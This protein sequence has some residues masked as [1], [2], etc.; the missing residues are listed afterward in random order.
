MKSSSERSALYYAMSTITT[1]N[2]EESLSNDWA[3]GEGIE[4]ALK[5]WLEND[6]HIIHP[7]SCTT[8]TPASSDESNAFD[9]ATLYAKKI[10]GFSSKGE[11]SLESN[12]LNNDGGQLKKP[13]VMILNT[14]TIKAASEQDTQAIGGSH[15]QCC[16]ILPKNYKPL[17]KDNNLNNVSEI[18]FYLDSVSP[19]KMPRVFETAFREGCKDLFISEKKSYDHDIPPA[20]PHATIIDNVNIRPQA[21]GYDCGWWAVYNALMIVFTGDT[22]YLKQFEDLK[23]GD[24]SPALKLRTLLPELT[25]MTIQQ[26][27]EKLSNHGSKL[28]S[29]LA[30]KE[31]SAN[32]ALFHGPAGGR[33]E[34]AQSPA[35]KVANDNA[36]P[37]KIDVL[38]DDWA[39]SIPNAINSVPVDDC[40]RR[41]LKDYSH[42]F[43]KDL[44]DEKFINL[45]ITT[46]E[47]SIQRQQS[48]VSS[49]II[50]ADYDEE[51]VIGIKNIFDDV[52]AGEEIKKT[53]KVVIYGK[54]GTGKS[55][56]CQHIARKKGEMFGRGIESTIHIKL[57]QFIN[58]GKD[59]R[60]PESTEGAEILAKFLKDRY[61]G[62]TYDGKPGIDDIKKYLVEKGN[63]TL[64][65]LDGYDEVESQLRANSTFRETINIILKNKEF[66]VIV[67]TRPAKI[68]IN[69]VEFGFDKELE[70][71]GFTQQS[72]QE[73]ITKFYGTIDESTK[74]YTSTEQSHA[75]EKYVLFNPTLLNIATVPLNLDL[76]C[77]TWDRIPFDEIK[78]KGDD[79]QSI[80]NRAKRIVTVA[81]LYQMVT[82][83]I[84]DYQVSKGS[85][86]RKREILLRYLES[87]AHMGIKDQQSY[88][89]ID[90]VK[91][92]IGPQDKILQTRSL[93]K[94]LLD[95]G[96]IRSVEIN[97]A[98][99][100]I[101][102]HQTFMEYFMARKIARGFQDS[103]RVA[104][105][106]SVAIIRNLEN[107]YDP[108]YEV[109]WSRVVGI[110]SSRYIEKGDK[111][112]LLKFWD[113][114]ENEPREILG[115]IHNELAVKLLKECDSKAK[116]EIP[117]LK[118]LNERYS[119]LEDT[120]T[121]L[122]NL[123]QSDEPLALRLQAME[124]L[125]QI[126][127][128]S[129]DEVKTEIISVLDN[130][131][132]TDQMLEINLYASESLLRL[133]QVKDKYIDK[134]L[135][136]LNEFTLGIKL[137]DRLFKVTLANYCLCALGES[138]VITE[139]LE[140][141]LLEALVKKFK[142][143]AGRL[144]GEEK[145]VEKSMFRKVVQHNITAAGILIKI[146]SKYIDQA[147]NL[148]VGK[149]ADSDPDIKQSTV[150]IL[151]K[152]KWDVRVK[153]K[154]DQ[155][156]LSEDNT[157]KDTIRRIDTILPLRTIP[158]KIL[159]GIYAERMR[160]DRINQLFLKPV[161]A[162]LSSPKALKALFYASYI[163]K[164]IL[165][166]LSKHLVPIVIPIIFL[167][168][169]P[170][171]INCY[172]DPRL[173]AVLD[174]VISNDISENELE[175][176]TISQINAK[177]GNFL[178]RSNIIT[179]WGKN[180][181]LNLSMAIQL[182]CST[183]QS[184]W[185]EP[186]KDI[187]FIRK[188][189]KAF[190][191]VEEGK[192]IKCVKATKRE[193][194]DFGD[195]GITKIELT[196]NL[197]HTK[198]V[199]KALRIAYEAA[200]L[201]VNV[202]DY[203]LSNTSL[204]VTK[205]SDLSKEIEDLMKKPYRLPQEKA[206]RE[207]ASIGN[208]MKVKEIF[209]SNDI[210]VNGKDP[211]TGN[212]ALMLAVMNE[213]WD[214][215]KYLIDEKGADVTFCNNKGDTVLYIIETARKTER[216]IKD[217]YIN[218]IIEKSF[219][220]NYHLKSILLD[221]ADDYKL[222]SS[223]EQ[224]EEVF[225]KL[226][227][228]LTGENTSWKQ[229]PKVLQLQKIHL[230][231]TV[232]I[233]IENSKEATTTGG[234]SSKALRIRLQVY[235]ELFI[236]I[237]VKDV[238]NNFPTKANSGDYS[239]EEI[240]NKLF[241]EIK[242][243]LGT[244]IEDR[245]RISYRF[246]PLLSYRRASNILSK[247]VAME[248][249]NE[250]IIPT[251]FEFIDVIKAIDADGTEKIT[252]KPKAHQ[253][254]LALY[255]VEGNKI[256]L[257]IDNRWLSSPDKEFFDRKVHGVDPWMKNSTIKSF[258]VGVIDLSIIRHKKALVKYLVEVNKEG[259]DQE[260]LSTI[261]G[262]SLD[263]DIKYNSKRSSP[264]I[265]KLIKSWQ[266]HKIQNDAEN[267][268]LSSYNLGISARCEK[269]LYDWL[270]QK[271]L[272]YIPSLKISM[273]KKNDGFYVNRIANEL[274]AIGI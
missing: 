28:T 222:C 101:F 65:I 202:F 74:Q 155:F 64:F 104:Y 198:E 211:K 171:I 57:K 19:K 263:N 220:K 135:N 272:E 16:V 53:K 227:T 141:C 30:L 193:G 240:L 268:I 247:S 219:V 82:E 20:F 174:N 162:V 97:Q 221:A 234:D 42:T 224:R 86:S 264:A 274:T 203:Y 223:N 200:N 140:Q 79:G 59:I 50:N 45:V 100:I 102:I 58:Y 27:T 124:M 72:I 113:A 262:E 9:G 83:D 106:E 54:P 212:T 182:F 185:L 112:S 110:L 23:E 52:K 7:D 173:S 204:N 36:V 15:W 55:T 170:N 230:D 40:I 261:Y 21:E 265:E 189:I 238:K 273:T 125:V 78:T 39:T 119:K 115:S 167:L 266:Y 208:L 131:V 31:E 271:E 22:E 37:V 126:H 206:L 249:R 122:L 194:Q 195:A 157:V 76:I 123:V 207:A 214:V 67:T 107:K 176:S 105:N 252:R 38:N 121:N 10:S 77:R 251:G 205:D 56:L 129:D 269:S 143:L 137:S 239:S 144:T 142:K 2:V 215:M 148:L 84:L 210:D 216:P 51:K 4:T 70:N 175:A 154:L 62:I 150:E 61:I 85:V 178:N 138:K 99:N 267:C 245:T 91:K 128:E 241:Q 163:P 147:I 60:I 81:W 139:E 177:A 218:Y 179:D 92:L 184:A 8:A 114:F 151:A 44:I 32:N 246:D 169:A 43:T 164:E 134:F 17:C 34:E 231:D 197:E 248:I 136:E 89:P 33:R 24:R 98:E 68:H 93:L 18:I 87:I 257:R 133:G 66:N 256:I 96:L 258:I 108:Y 47:T 196:S 159:A 90:A 49:Y 172:L 103:E 111:L 250:I 12:I 242:V 5:Q 116:L 190:L 160:T 25:K 244:V 63:N 259:N 118:K 233:K 180:G 187:N 120:I 253:I 168:S 130:L 46:I 186:M 41:I 6:V 199:L 132:G 191:I 161:D 117:E 183:S 14:S 229:D 71:I 69:D 213:H 237:Y 181:L 225:N 209:Y 152:Y 260:K 94:D 95:T 11:K 188:D 254:Y 26:N 235:M 1:I 201:P 35:K 127:G 165:S 156:S 166:D 270:I 232:S 73:Y 149:L 255:K 243:I 226:A 109:I 145:L 192:I 146:N 13:I 228:T 75:L 29:L 158:V 3:T 48:L 88:I 80:P 217:N 236:K 153:E